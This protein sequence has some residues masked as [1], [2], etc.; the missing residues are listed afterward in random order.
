[1]MK[2]PSCF[3]SAL[4]K[5]LTA[6]F[7]LMSAVSASG[8]DDVP[9]SI[10]AVNYSDQEFEY[11][12]HDP[13]DK[14]NNGG[15]ESIGRFGAGGAMC[16]FSLPRKW[17]PDMKVKI[18]FTVYFPRRPDGSWPKTT[19]ST[20]A[21]VPQ[22]SQPQEL[23]VVRDVEG[24]MT[25]VVSNFE[26]DHPKWPGAVKGW[27]VPS[28]AYQ[29]DRADIYIRNRKGY[30]RAF[31]ELSEGMRDHPDTTAKE[32]WEFAEEYDRETLVGYS[33]YKDKRYQEYLLDRFNKSLAEDRI[34]LRKLEAAR[35]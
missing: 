10:H 15:G 22:Y 3:K 6:S 30:I 16:C 5:T 24:K 23:W 9:V 14:S 8:S 34:T 2:T 32:M 13:K 18:D 19:N 29:R 20:L 17:R 35:P 26:P 1:M 28:I 21:D 27:P 31:E 4:I 33:G 25:I 12:V 11:T 7:L